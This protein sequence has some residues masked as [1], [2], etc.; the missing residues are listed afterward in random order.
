MQLPIGAEGHYKGVIDLVTMKAL[1]WEGEELG[2]NVGR[3]ATIPADLSRRPR[4]T[5][6]NC[7]ETVASVD[8]DLLE[9]F[10]GD[11]E[12]AVDELRAAIRAGTIAD[13]IVPVLNGS[14][15]KNKGVQPLLDAVVVY[16]PSPLDLPAGRRAPTSRAT[17]RSSA[18]PTTTS[19]S[20]RWPS[21]S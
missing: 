15:F 1:V 21:R 2:A 7:I 17:R 8:E 11:E 13:E 14:A 3:R 12:I 9:K 4:S 18:R 6:P 20:R 19:H 16:L 5:A 10:V